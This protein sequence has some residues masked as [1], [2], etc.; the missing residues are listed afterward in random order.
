[1]TRPVFQS[2]ISSY[3]PLNIWNIWLKARIV[4]R[5]ETPIAKEGHGNNTWLGDFSKQE[6][7][8][9]TKR[10]LLGKGTV[11]SRD[12]VILNLSAPRSNSNMYARKNIRN[13]WS[14]VF[15][16]VRAEGK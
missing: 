10:P 14:D 3:Y 11:T 2:I 15:Y 8:N 5:D 1:M 9:E 7:W 12:L 13:I 16:K 6:L 4:E